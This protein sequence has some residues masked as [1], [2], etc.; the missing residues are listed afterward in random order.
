MMLTKIE[1]FLRISGMSATEFG[2]RVA[3]DPRL[4]HDLR[5]GRE[6]GPRMNARIASFIGGQR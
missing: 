1:K 5:K 4:V 6:A 2:Q 3:H